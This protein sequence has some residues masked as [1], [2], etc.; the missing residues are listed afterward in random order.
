MDA[1]A[2][3][4]AVHDREAALYDERFAIAFDGR[5][6]TTVRRDLERVAGQ[7]T[8]GERAL[9][10]CCGTGFA[11]VGMAAAGLAEEVYACDLSPKMI[12]QTIANA[13]RVGVA[14]RAAVCDGERLPYRDGCFDLIVAR[15][16]LHHLPDPVS[17]LGEL[18][19]VL[20]AGGRVIVLAEPTPSGE[21]QVAAVVGSLARTVEAARKVFRRPGDKEHHNWELASMAANL[22]T[23][24]PTDLEAVAFAAG[25]RDVQ[26]ST[27]WWSW[28]LALGLNYYASGESR[29]IAENA[30]LRTLRFAFVDGAN[31]LDRMVC[32]RLVPAKYRH[33]VQAVLR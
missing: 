14:I 28:V 19:R 10:Y 3:N 29:L 15:G 17:A 24:T 7:V 23:F 9:D 26:T 18:R 27:A 20:A 8:P 21:A 5:L 11:A 12:R 22:H 2:L 32:E 1:K 33:T 13:E 30:L 16:A 4:A 25:F 6:A 31:A